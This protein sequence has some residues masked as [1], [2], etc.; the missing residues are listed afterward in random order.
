MPLTPAITA[1]AAEGERIAEA[2]RSGRLDRGAG[3][4]A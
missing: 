4:L 3:V 1:G 2:V